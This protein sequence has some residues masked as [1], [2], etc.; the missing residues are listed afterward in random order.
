MEN[1]TDTVLLS[2]NDQKRNVLF[3]AY[4]GE[5]AEFLGIVSG[6]GY[7]NHYPEQDKYVL[8]IAGH[9]EEDRDY[10]THYVVELVTRLFN[11]KPAIVFRKTEKSMYVRV[12]SK[13]IISFLSSAGFKKGYKGNFEVP[14]WILKD[15]SFFIS[16]IRGYFDTD[17]SVTFLRNR[18]TVAPYPKISLASISENSTASI[19][20]FLNRKGFKTNIHIERG[21]DKRTQKNK[22]INRITLNGRGNMKKWVEIVGFHNPKHVKKI[23]QNSSVYALVSNNSSLTASTP[24]FI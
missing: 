18:K 7:M 6:D 1:F 22:E 13:G 23:M 16:Y 11:I 4:S 8:E 9:S 19:N 3:P 24:T 21:F 17:S 2:R 10:L 15:E 20:E 14:D 5:L 12:I